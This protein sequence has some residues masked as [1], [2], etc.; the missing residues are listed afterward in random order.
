MQ[1]STSFLPSFSYRVS[2]LSTSRTLNHKIWPLDLVYRVL[3]SFSMVK[4]TKL[5]EMQTGPSFLPSFSYRVSFFSS[6]SWTGTDLE[7]KLWPIDLV[8]RVLPSFT[9]FSRMDWSGQPE[10]RIGPPYFTEFLLPS[11]L[12]ES[13]P[14]PILRNISFNGI[15]VYLILT[16][17]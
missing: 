7:S 14:G 6:Y 3:P 1:T 11:F 13:T 5:P 15:A 9:E 2:F 10:R 16:N 4:W 12:F 17:L 8:Y